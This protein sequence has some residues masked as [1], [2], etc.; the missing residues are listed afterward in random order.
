MYAYRGK[1]LIAALLT[2]ISGCTTSDDP[3]VAFQQGDFE[4]AYELWRPLAAKGDPEAENYLGVHYYMGL[5]VRRDY[6]KALHWYESAAR[7]GYPSA[8]RH[9]GDM[10]YSGYGTQ[11]DYYKAFIWYF[12]A[13]QQGNEDAKLK[14]DSITSENKLTPNQQMHAKIEANEFITDPKNRFAS[15]D[16]YVRDDDKLSER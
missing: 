5:G 14:L 8:Q 3:K 10:F 1:L 9:Y 6:A 16:T 2:L 15:H 11:R 12:A 13:S 4:T 7:K